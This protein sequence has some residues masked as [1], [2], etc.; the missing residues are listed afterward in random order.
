M[1]NKMPEKIGEVVFKGENLEIYQST[2]KGGRPAIF[3]EEAG[4]GHVP[5]TA[6]TINLPEQPLTEGEILIKNW[7][8]NE[9]IAPW[10]L[11][12]TELFEDTGVV[13]N[14]GFV[15]A[16]IWRFKKEE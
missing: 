4:P 10:V 15:Q 3:L 2:Y 7:T 11:E 12:H 6:L 5:F 16:P 14:T 1:N 9:E 13:V 8:E